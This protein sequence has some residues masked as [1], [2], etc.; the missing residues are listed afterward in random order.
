M[1]TKMIVAPAY[2]AL[3][4]DLT[5]R[6]PGTLADRLFEDILLAITRGELAPGSKIS[7]PM[8]VRRYG[9]SRG[10]LREALNR[11]QERKL[12]T[13]SAN[14][15]A[16][17]AERTPQALK[18]F[19]TVRGSLEALAVREAVMRCSDA[20][21]AEL[22]ETVI[23]YEAEVDSLPPADPYMDVI[24]DRD[25]HFMIAQMSRNP[26]LIALLCDE[27]YPLL[28]FFRTHTNYPKIR[29][30]QSVQEHRQILAAMENRDAELAE[31]LMR[32]HIAAASQSRQEALRT[33]GPNRP[34]APARP[35]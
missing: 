21:L 22:H 19:F 8:L 3:A 6:P 29:R 27:L 35:R 4:E 25:F 32:R 2:E 7:E 5:R 12:V 13:R 30:K 18:D 17:V 9:V 14:Q 34:P 26:Y 31:I 1:T 23:R 28:R 20:E 33:A 16:R 11:L 10:T 24:A 15:S